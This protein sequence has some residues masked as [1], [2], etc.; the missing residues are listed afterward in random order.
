MY[1]GCGG[2]FIVL[3]SFVGWL[4]RLVGDV[5]VWDGLVI[6]PGFYSSVGGKYWC[7]I[8]MG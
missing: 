7:S 5:N 8:L 2:K 3:Y 6:Y 1:V 4:L